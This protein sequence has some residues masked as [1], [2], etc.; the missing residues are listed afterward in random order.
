MEPDIQLVEDKTPAESIVQLAE[1]IIERK[2]AILSGA[3]EI[4]MAELDNGAFLKLVS[5]GVSIREGVRFKFNI[6][7]SQS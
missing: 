7:F 2:E 1:F 5:F 6:D 3:Y 4:E